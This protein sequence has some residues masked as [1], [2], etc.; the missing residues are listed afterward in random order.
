MY[1]RMHLENDKTRF[2]KFKTFLGLLS[3][4]PSRF[5]TRLSSLVT[6][7]NHLSVKPYTLH[8]LFH[9]HPLINSL[10]TQV[11]NLSTR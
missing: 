7:Q 10:L 11:S 1:M 6:I 5:I 4:D 2:A 8:M 3:H 9:T